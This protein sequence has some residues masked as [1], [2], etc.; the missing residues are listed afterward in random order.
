MRLLKGNK[1]EENKMK[2]YNI[3]VTCAD[4][5][6]C[7]D[8]SACGNGGGYWQPYGDCTVCLEDGTILRVKY[9]DTSCGDY[10]ARWD[11]TITCGVESWYLYVDEIGADAETQAEH[12][13]HNTAVIAALERRFGIDVIDLIH[14]VKHAI[15]DAARDKY[16]DDM[17]KE[18]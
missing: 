7:Y 2:E 6:P 18:D 11:M 16:M 17:Y 15:S 1:K 3:N 4:Y 12:D 5:D 13:A 14:Q 10:G 8:P 9:D